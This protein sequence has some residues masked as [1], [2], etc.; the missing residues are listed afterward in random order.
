MKNREFMTWE[1]YEE[2]IRF[3]DNFYWQ[4]EIRRK[5]LKNALKEHMFFN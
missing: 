4:Q 2:K 3:L 5:S 1:L